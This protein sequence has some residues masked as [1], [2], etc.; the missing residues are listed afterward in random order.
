M[1][2]KNP[3]LIFFAPTACDEKKTEISAVSFFEHTLLLGNYIL[4][5]E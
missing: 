5:L 1:P 4:Q 2:N 3:C